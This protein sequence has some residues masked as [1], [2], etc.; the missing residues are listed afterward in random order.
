[1]PYP[2]RHFSLVR[3]TSILLL[4]IPAAVLASPTDWYT[5]PVAFGN[6]LP[7]GQHVAD[8]FNAMALGTATNPLVFS[9]ISIFA[10]TGLTV[11][12]VTSPPSDHWLRTTV[13]NTSIIIQST[14][15]W[16]RIVA[17][18]ADFFLTNATAA[19]QTGSLV[20][21][22]EFTDTSTDT[23]T[24]TNPT[25]STFTG[26]IAPA[27]SYIQSLTLS[28]TTAFRFVNMNNLYVQYQHVDPP[29]PVSEPSSGFLFSIAALYL[30][31]T[32]KHRPTIP[33]G[34]INRRRVPAQ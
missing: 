28:T 9:P 8:D 27:N 26:Y 2:N 33:T 23:K 20:A 1:M 31:A 30:W 22:I 17:I 24:I 14:S 34:R 4:S 18:G 3:W 21:T 5:D 13:R 16:D 7:S 32:H 10:N 6:H 19:T 25:F 29:H 11:S 12:T 15:S